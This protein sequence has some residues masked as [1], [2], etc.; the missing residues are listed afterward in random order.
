MIRWLKIARAELTRDIKTSLRYP[1]EL[2]TGILIL[3]VLFMGLFLGAQM[4]AGKAASALSGDLDGVV[5]GY[6]MWFVALMSIN[7]V[8]VDIE[9]ES[10]QG[11]LEQVYIHEIGRAH[12]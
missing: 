11:T 2:A 7:T 10:R 9:L 5:I 12:V 6:I 4:I 8:S 1:L 3:Y